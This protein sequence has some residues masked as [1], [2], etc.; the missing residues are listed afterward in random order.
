MSELKSSWSSADRPPPSAGSFLR[1]LCWHN[2]RTTE[3]QPRPHGL[4][5]PSNVAPGTAT[6]GQARTG[7]S[8]DKNSGALV[9]SHEGSEGWLWLQVPA[10]LLAGGRGGGGAWPALRKGHGH[11][12]SVGSGG[13]R[14]CLLPGAPAV[15]VVAWGH[16]S[17]PQPGGRAGNYC[18][19]CSVLSYYHAHKSFRA[20]VSKMSCRTRPGFTPEIFNLQSRAEPAAAHGLGTRARLLAAAGAAFSGSGWSTSPGPGRG[21]SAAR[22]AGCRARGLGDPGPTGGAVRGRQGPLLQ[23]RPK[24]WWLPLLLRPLGATTR[25]TGLVQPPAGPAPSPVPSFQQSPR[26]PGGHR[27]ALRQESTS[28]TRG[29]LPPP[30]PLVRPA[31]P[32]G[33]WQSCDDLVEF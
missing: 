25:D 5:G 23:L 29:P 24:A 9:H 15:E 7:R 27:A 18:N 3:G 19:C 4:R 33:G 30:A 2:R 20:S 12:N 26:M 1:A 32:P 22:G 10:L 14:P 31:P 21:R 6:R 28:R 13:D 16:V 17:P 8:S 11:G